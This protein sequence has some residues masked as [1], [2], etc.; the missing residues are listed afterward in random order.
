MCLRNVNVKS[1]FARRFTPT[2]Y[3]MIVRYKTAYYT[4]YL[5]C[6]M[7]MIYAGVKDPAS[8]RLARDICCRI[9]EFFQ[10]QDDFLDCFG[11]P[12]VIGKVGTDIQDNKCSWLVVQAL[13][14]ASKAQKAVLLENYAIDDEAKVSF[15][16]GC[17]EGVKIVESVSWGLL[18]RENDGVFETR[19]IKGGFVRWNVDNR[20]MYVS[21][22]PP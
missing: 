20:C 17:F 14:R 21:V 2:R 16:I 9:G 15:W 3:R 5:P 18:C 11:D 13:E 7:G 12:K 4:F 19:R 1:V 6:A 8:Y 22:C 10:I